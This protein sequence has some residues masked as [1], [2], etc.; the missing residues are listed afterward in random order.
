MKKLNAV[1]QIELDLSCQTDYILKKNFHYWT[2]QKFR[3]YKM[4]VAY[5]PGVSDVRKIWLKK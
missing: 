4:H 3:T 2:K 1:K 5:H